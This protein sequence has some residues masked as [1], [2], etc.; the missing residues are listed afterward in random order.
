MVATSEGIMRVVLVTR[1]KVI[2]DT[3]QDYFKDWGKASVLLTKVSR[4]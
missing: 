3:D 1:R 2:R 4:R